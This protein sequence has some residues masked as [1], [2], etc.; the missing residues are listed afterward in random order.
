MHTT[1][2]SKISD[3]P[4]LQHSTRVLW[5]VIVGVAVFRGLLVHWQRQRGIYDIYKLAGEHWLAGNNIYD[6]R[7]SLIGF[8]YAPLIAAFMS[9]L[10]K[11]PD[12]VGSIL[13]RT[14]NVAVFIVGAFAFLDRV[15]CAPRRTRAEAAFWLV[16]APLAFSGLTDLQVNALATGLMMLAVAALPQSK[17][18][19]A[20]A[21]LTGAVLLKAYPIALML[22]IILLWPRQMG[23]RCA[24]ALLLGLAA[25]FLLQRP[26]F[27]W[28]QYHRWFH[29]M[30][31]NE[32]HHLPMNLWYRDVRL[33]LG[34]MG[35]FV[36][37][38][39]YLVLQL[40]AALWVAGVVVSLQRKPINWRL[41]LGTL[42]GMTAGWMLA[43]GPAS[44]GVTYIM[45]APALTWLTV[46]ALTQPH[47]KAWRW[48][49]VTLFACFAATELSLWF[50]FGR[51]LRNLGPQPVA[52][53][54]FMVFLTSL[55]FA[56]AVKRSSAQ[57]DL[58]IFAPETRI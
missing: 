6:N 29:L 4:K 54:L 35:V 28:D 22:P 41:H 27:V 13:F 48:A 34:R 25:P 16:L 24:L 56:P 19:F 53:V 2:A 18:N 3:S 23:W 47:A 51:A 26:A 40:A 42:Y 37:D 10:A 32:R 30:L 14:V 55:Q 49:I 17:W 31:L 12:V 15:V 44:E 43:F 33:P 46:D 39:A 57:A 58:P 45:L 1:L 9:P 11:V 5:I 8:R 38:R 20:A 21:C 50:P 7:D 52:A 36:S